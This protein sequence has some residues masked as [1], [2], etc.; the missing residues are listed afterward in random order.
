MNKKKNKP[1][2]EHWEIIKTI[3]SG[4]QGQT[5][6]VQPRN[7]SYPPGQYVFKELHRQK[8]CERRG[9]MRREVIALTT[10]EHPGIPKI[11]DENSQYFADLDTPLYFVSEFVPGATLLE[12]ITAEKTMNLTD[13]VM[14]IIKLLDILEYCHNADTLH[15]DIK[16][17]NIMIKN[18]DIQNPVLID[19]GL[20]FNRDDDSNMNLTATGQQLGNRFLQLPELLEKSS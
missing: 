9:R 19:F 17:D 3:G 5:S 16:P 6:L 1:W 2:S 20:S 14:F 12:F 8:D 10:L 13:A 11:I 7:N 15:R 4:G 18:D